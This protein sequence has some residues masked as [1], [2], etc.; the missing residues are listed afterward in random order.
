MGV[1]ATAPV[2]PF[3][4]VS[5]AAEPE[6]LTSSPVVVL[7][8]NILS[9]LSVV[10]TALVISSSAAVVVVSNV[11]PPMQLGRRK[12]GSSMDQLN[13]I[14]WSGVPDITSVRIVMLPTV[15]PRVVLL[16]S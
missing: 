8:K 7:Y 15:K 12:L 10:L 3:L 11:K 13:G 9:R 5:P 16:E 2:A 4:H 1:C 14:A 6:A